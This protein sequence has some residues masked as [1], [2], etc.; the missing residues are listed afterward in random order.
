MR[1]TIKIAMN[2]LTSNFPV[3]R[4]NSYVSVS[5]LRTESSSAS[6]PMVA[7]SGSDAI[8]LVEDDRMIRDLARRILTQAGFN[9]LEADSAEQAIEVWD[10]HANRI[11]LM[12]TDVCIP[13]RATGL[14]LA[15]RFSAD[16]PDLKVIYTSGFSPDMAANDGQLKSNINFLAKPYNPASLVK[17][18]REFLHPIAG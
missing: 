4:P 9:V 7:P 11:D 13:Y 5:T 15:R 8:L 3:S 10:E 2:T 6:S 14:E 16:K 18:V 1:Q 17:I 12:L